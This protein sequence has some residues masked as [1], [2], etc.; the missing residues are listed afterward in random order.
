[1]YVDVRV[2]LR[3]SLK[4][5]FGRIAGQPLLVIDIGGH[6]E[7][8]LVRRLYYGSMLSYAHRDQTE[9]Q[10]ICGTMQIY[11]E[12]GG[13]DKVGK[14][15]MQFSSSDARYRPAGADYRSSPRLE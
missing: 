2:R 6:G 4:A 5:A 1:M 8:L 9:G 15:L 10:R 11:I 14:A 3:A 7:E 12:T 13:P